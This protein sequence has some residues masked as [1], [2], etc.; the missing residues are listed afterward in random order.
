MINLIVGVIG[1][2][3]YELCDNTKKQY[4]AIYYHFDQLYNG[5]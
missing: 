3:L 2:T 5:K 1:K 4:L